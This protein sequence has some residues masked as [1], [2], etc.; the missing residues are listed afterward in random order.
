M[1]MQTDESD[2]YVL[3]DQRAAEGLGLADEESRIARELFAYMASSPVGFALAEA[4]GYS[5]QPKIYRVRKSLLEKILSD[6]QKEQ[7]KDGE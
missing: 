5:L 6:I 4:C 3:I 2:P 7:E 1:I